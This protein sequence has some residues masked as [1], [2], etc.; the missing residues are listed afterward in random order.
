MES[1]MV[2]RCCRSRCIEEQASICSADVP[3]ALAPKP[4][5]APIVQVSPSALAPPI[6]PAPLS[7]LPL[8]CGANFTLCEKVWVA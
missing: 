2:R 7:V 5:I 6:G 1:P 4:A 3:N 8:T